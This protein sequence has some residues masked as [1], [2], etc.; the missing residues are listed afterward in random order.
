MSQKQPNANGKPSKRTIFDCIE[1][2]PG[3]RGPSPHIASHTPT[4]K[5]TAM[6]PSDMTS[7]IFFG[8]SSA[9]PRA[10]NSP[11]CSGPQISLRQFGRLAADQCPFRTHT[12]PNCAPLTAALRRIICPTL[13]AGPDGDFPII[14]P[15]IDQSLADCGPTMPPF[16][17]QHSR[18]DAGRFVLQSC[19]RFL[20]LLVA[21]IFS[22]SISL[23]IEGRFPT[24]LPSRNNIAFE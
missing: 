6:D 1:K 20:D 5:N 2:C 22:H 12:R 21:V 10:I 11:G 9:S 15:P 3:P 14:Y 24:F 7:R 18:N 19:N 16:A 13:A 23:T 8:I 17:G 4:P